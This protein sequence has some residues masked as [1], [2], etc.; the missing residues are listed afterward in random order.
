[1]SFYVAP[2][3][4]HREELKRLREHLADYPAITSDDPLGKYLKV[5]NAAGEELHFCLVADLAR[6][7]CVYVVHEKTADKKPTRVLLDENKQPLAA[8]CAFATINLAR[9][10]P[11]DLRGAYALLCKVHPGVVLP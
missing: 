1:M 9:E 3:V 7:T 8:S 11:V 10:L 2:V 6:M 4:V 5:F